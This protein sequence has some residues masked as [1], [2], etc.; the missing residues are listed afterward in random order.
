MKSIKLNAKEE[1]IL[2]AKEMELIKG[3]EKCCG[4]ACYYRNVG[5]S[6][7]DDNMDANRLGGGLQSPQ[8]TRD[9][10]WITQDGKDRW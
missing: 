9:Y 4:C 8:L 3:G 7:I 1:N 5:G 6:S 10:V 2:N